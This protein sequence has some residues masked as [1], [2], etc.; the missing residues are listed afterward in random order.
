MVEIIKNIKNFNYKN[1]N[2]NPAVKAKK[3][4]QRFE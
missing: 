1:F 2:F 3:S 4:L